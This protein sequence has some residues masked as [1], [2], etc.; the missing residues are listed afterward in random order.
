MDNKWNLVTLRPRS[1]LRQNALI[2][3]LILSNINCLLLMSSNASNPAWRTSDHYTYKWSTVKHSISNTANRLPLN[4]KPDN[5]CAYIP[6]INTNNCCINLNMQII[7]SL[8]IQYL[9]RIP[10]CCQ[11]NT[12]PVFIPWSQ[13]HQQ[14]P[15]L[16]L[17]LHC[18]LIRWIADHQLLAFFLYI[19]W[20]GWWISS[21]SIHRLLLLVI[22]VILLPSWRG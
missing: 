3:V 17:I 7:S 15:F 12:S 11:G 2:L 22:F 21:G 10:V 18:I 5:I 19:V 14:V 8:S 1:I 16:L 4:Q 13:P 6:N 20:R 9:C